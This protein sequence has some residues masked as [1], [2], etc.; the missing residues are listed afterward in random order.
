MVAR[1]EV[2]YFYLP[3]SAGI[4]AANRGGA[5]LDATQDLVSWVQSHGTVVP[6]S[7]WSGAA[8]QGDGSTQSRSGGW[9]LYDCTP[10]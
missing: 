3:Q 1:D 5:A 8:V 7:T 6:A 10:Q 9:Q 4:S 2:R